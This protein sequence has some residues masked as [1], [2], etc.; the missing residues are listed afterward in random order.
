MNI[1]E[2]IAEL[3]E[4]KEKHG[5]L[6][7]KMCWDEFHWNFESLLGVN[8]VEQIA[9]L[10]DHILIIPHSKGPKLTYYDR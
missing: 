6:P 10:K 7:L 5:D 2:M 1:T 3:E 8:E 9:F 4:L